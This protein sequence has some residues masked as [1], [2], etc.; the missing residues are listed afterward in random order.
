MDMKNIY[1]RIFLVVICS[2]RL[3]Y[4]HS[5]CMQTEVEECTTDIQNLSISDANRFPDDLIIE[6]LFSRYL[7]KSIE[8]LLRDLSNFGITCRRFKNIIY[9]LFP[10]RDEFRRV[11]DNINFNACTIVHLLAATDRAKSLDF[12]FRNLDRENVKKVVNECAWDNLCTPL[13]YASFYGHHNCVR[14]LLRYGAGP[15]IYDGKSNTPLHYAAATGNFSLVELLCKKGAKINV[16]NCDGFT[17]LNFANNNIQIRQF[18]EEMGAIE[19]QGCTQ[20][21]ERLIKHASSGNLDQVE[22]LL[23][24]G[25]N[26]N[27]QDFNEFTALHLAIYHCQWEVAEKLIAYGANI[28]AQD[29]DNQTP[30]LVAVEKC[31]LSIIKSCIANGGQVN[32]RDRQGSTALHEATKEDCWELVELLLEAGAKNYLDL[33]N[34]YGWAPLHYSAGWK[35]DEIRKKLI[36]EYGADASLRDKEGYSVWDIYNIMKANI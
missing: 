25:A 3:F 2:A 16:K 36:N 7:D 21:D 13:H 30:L 23:E 33:Q 4:F 14:I 15:N 11:E 17:P 19:G 24:D 26:I 8:N 9:K 32:A 6:I 27:A 22:Q 18:L 34:V 20:Q 12:I 31:Y 5:F 1:Y 35:Q 28:N 29:Y 10:T